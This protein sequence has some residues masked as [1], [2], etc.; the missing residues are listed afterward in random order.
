M[1][2]RNHKRRTTRLTLLA[3]VVLIITSSGFVSAADERPNIV[4]II[5]DDHGWPYYGFMGSELVRT[6]R[7]DRLA[8]GGTLFLNAYNT[9]SLC[10]PSLR[11]ILTGLY[12][13]QFELHAGRLGRQNRKLTGSRGQ[14]VERM[15]TLPRVLAR[16]GYA[17]FQAGKLWDGTHQ[18]SGFTDGMTGTPAVASN[19][20]RRNAAGLELGRKTLDPAFS[21]LRSNRDGPFFLWFGLQL[22]HVPHNAP[23][24]FAAPYEGRGLSK[25]AV[26]YFANCSWEDDVVRRLLAFLDD[27]GLRENTLVVYLS[28]NGWEQPRSGPIARGGGRQGKNSMHEMGFRTPLIFSWPDHVRAGRRIDDP[29]STVDLYPTLLGLAGVTVPGGRNGIDLG[30]TLE[31]RTQPAR[32][33]MIGA[34]FTLADSRQRPAYKDFIGDAYYVRDGDWYY[35]LW[36]GTRNGHVLFNKRDDPNEQ[37]DVAHLHPERALAYREDV[38]SWLDEIGVGRR[39]LGWSPPWVRALQAGEKAHD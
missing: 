2:P 29:V 10:R 32:T 35:I 15:E 8:E 3:T 31:G 20:Y 18:Q 26:A 6:P 13:H 24:K 12:P 30:P 11:S 7:L 34:Q 39:R 23:A 14:P 25:G 28:D 37:T 33:K 16:A 19:A 5:G 22:P 36:G 1:R 9:A 21:W 17:T 4:L 38:M 27:E